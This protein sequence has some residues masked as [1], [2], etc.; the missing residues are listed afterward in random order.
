MSYYLDIAGKFGGVWM[1][2]AWLDRFGEKWLLLDGNVKYPAR[3]WANRNL[4]LAELK[5]EGWTIKP[6]RKPISR[7]N[8]RKRIQGYA[9]VRTIH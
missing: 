2:F 6:L 1:Q 9:M 7:G 8:P 3:C 4:A 5:E